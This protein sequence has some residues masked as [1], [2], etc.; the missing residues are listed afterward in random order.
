MIPHFQA[1]D[2]CSIV[3]C[4]PYPHRT[5]STLSFLLVAATENRISFLKKSNINLYHSCFDVTPI[6]WLAIKKAV[7]VDLPFSCIK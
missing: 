2:L 3:P 5:A 4:N 1:I 6:L 7:L